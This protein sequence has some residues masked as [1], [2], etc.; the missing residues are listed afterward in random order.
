MVVVARRA[1]RGKVVYGTAYQERVIVYEADRVWQADLPFSD[2]V[3]CLPIRCR[4]MPD[5]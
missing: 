4:Y 5:I 3:A 2:L 1:S